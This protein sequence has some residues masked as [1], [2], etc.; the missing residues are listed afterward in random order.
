[1]EKTETPLGN[2][3]ARRAD[4]AHRLYASVGVYLCV[5]GEIARSRTPTLAEDGERGIEQK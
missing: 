2:S 5:P 3:K 4:K 1:L